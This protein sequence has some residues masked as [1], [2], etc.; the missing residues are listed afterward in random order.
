LFSDPK[1]LIY[2]LL[3]GLQVSNPKELTPFSSFWSIDIGNNYHYI[4][5]K[6]KKN[7]N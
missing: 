6:F 7:L 4:E 2:S 3:F 1:Q 5:I